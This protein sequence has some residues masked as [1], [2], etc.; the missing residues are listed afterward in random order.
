MR[1]FVYTDGSSSHEKGTASSAYLILTEDKYIMDGTYKFEDSV[2]SNIS[3]LNAIL[4][5]ARAINEIVNEDDIIIFVT[6]SKSSLNLIN[7]IIK[8][9]YSFNLSTDLEREVQQT[10][11]DLSSK[12]KKLSI[13][14]VRA[15]KKEVNSPNRIVD[16]LA[17]K[18]S[19]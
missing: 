3:E 17:R 16:L 9:N 7:M 15:H 10:L 2:N 4:I 1:Y 6:D 12:V 14:K 18:E 13:M 8:S 11:K 5:G 19:R